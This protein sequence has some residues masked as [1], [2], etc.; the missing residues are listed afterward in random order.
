MLAPSLAKFGPLGIKEFEVF[1]LPYIIPDRATLLR[2]F[3][4]PAGRGLMQKLEPKGIHG[5]AY[6][7]HGF[8]IMTANRPLRKPEDYLGQKLRIQ[9][10]KVLQAQMLALGAVPQV[11]ALS[12]VYQAMQTGLVDGA[13]NTPSNIY[14]QNMHQVQK[15]AILTDHGYDGYLVI[16]NA[17]FWDGLPQDIRAQ[18]EQAMQEATAYVA[19]I[20]Q[21]ENEDAIAAIEAAGG[22][23]VIRLTAAEKEAL[24][25]ALLPVHKEMESRIGKDLIEAFYREAEAGG[26]GG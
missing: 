13:E 1:E 12:E 26:S 8:K 4:G 19:E 3:N 2:I 25:E 11:L 24:R 7:E 6:W 15:Y 9:S 5:L 23:E 17:K 14:S 20:A 18:L 10:S 21:K 22:T 16:V